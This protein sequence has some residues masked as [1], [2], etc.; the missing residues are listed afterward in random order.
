MNFGKNMGNTTMTI[1]NDT[2]WYVLD[3]M[4][5]PGFH[6]KTDSISVLRLVLESHVCTY[7]MLTKEELIESAKAQSEEDKEAWGSEQEVNEITEYEFAFPDDYCEMT[8]EEKVD[9]LMSTCCGAEFFYET[10]TNNEMRDE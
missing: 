3:K 9:A 8:E 4:S 6:L 7:C 2:R 10:F 1:S 5:G